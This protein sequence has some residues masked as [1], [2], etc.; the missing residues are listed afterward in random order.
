MEKTYYEAYAELDRR[1][2]WFTSR[3]RIIEAVVRRWSPAKET[4][5]VCDVG[6]GPTTTLSSLL[7]PSYNVVG[8]DVSPIA[9]EVARR[10][11][12]NAIECLSLSEYVSSGQ[13]AD[14]ILLLD[15]SLIHI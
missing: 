11:G 7:S 6:C 5:L 12:R 8:L 13:K 15:L 1:N 3:A 9:V 14:L 4:G 2:W 10:H